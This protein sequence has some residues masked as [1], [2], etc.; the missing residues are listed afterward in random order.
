M[1]F[2]AKV[3]EILDAEMTTPE[4]YGWF[5]LLFF[6]LSILAGVLLCVF[7]D[8]Q[9][10]QRVRRVVF[11]VAVA[12][13]ILE[14]YKQINYSFSYDGGTVTFDFE[15]YSFPFQFCSTPM[16]VGILTGI[17]R[18]G[19][20]HDALCAF[21]AT[22]A[23]FAGLS[24]MVYPVQIFI[25]TI[26]IN[27]QTCIC[28]GSMIAVGAYLLYSGY[29]KL[30]HKTILKAMAVFALAMLIAMI[31]NEVAHIVGIT[32]N[33]TFNMFFISPYED[34]SLPVY[35]LVQAVVPYPVCL[36]LYFGGFSLAAYLILL[37]AM[38]VNKL[39]HVVRREKA[40]VKS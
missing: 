31:M 5:H 1:E 20:V 25:G 14:V 23:I 26:G 3:L 27:I 19:K 33:E 13:V 16:Y 6:A 28:H 35:S 29:V 36:F 17:F 9:K 18:R 11:W 2:F 38:G 37:F 15:W 39:T 21:L 30:E 32:E 22:Y 24:V 7:H 10:P 40:L 4:P 34:P 8:P 12:V